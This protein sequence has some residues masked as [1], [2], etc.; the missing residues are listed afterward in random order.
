MGRVA[1]AL[2]LMVLVLGALALLLGGGGGRRTR[3]LA[4]VADVSASAWFGSLCTD[5]GRI[6]AAER[7]ER[8]VAFTARLFTTG[9]GSS[10]Q[11]STRFGPWRMEPSRF[12]LK[13]AGGGKGPDAVT[14]ALHDTCVALLPTQETPLFRAVRMAISEL[15]GEL[16]R[17]PLAEA[18]LVVRSDLLEEEDAVLTARWAP[19]AKG[20][21]AKPAASEPTARLDNRGMAVRLCGVT[22]R[23]VK[24]RT[25][26]PSVEVLEQ[27][28]RAE[29]TDP[30][31]VQV[32]AGCP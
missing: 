4:V 14:T 22:Q 31:G 23:R 28:W 19:P 5:V 16:D 30:E 8:G 3:H 27:A 9:D 29:F 18:V 6:D 24:P 10:G 13:G 17:D 7:P 12:L 2:L 1:A 32:H 25:R 11:E 21:K 26:L 15:R 20:S